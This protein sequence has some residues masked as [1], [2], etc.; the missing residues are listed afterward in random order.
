MCSD[1]V[2]AALFF[3]RRLHRERASPGCP[4]RASMAMV[5]DAE[6]G[7][8]DGAVPSSQFICCV[9]TPSW[10]EELGRHLAAQHE[11]GKRSDRQ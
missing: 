6:A 8:A 5:T 11:S 1:P 4:A 2:Q 7:T 10:Q 3:L 9:K